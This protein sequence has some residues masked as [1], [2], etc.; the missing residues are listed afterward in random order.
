MLTITIEE[1]VLVVRPAGINRAW[2]A[3]RELRVKLA[4]VLSVYAHPT[5]RASDTIFASRVE[6]ISEPLDRN[7]VGNVVIEIGGDS[8]GELEIGVFD[9]P[10]A[11]RAIGDAVA[12][13]KSR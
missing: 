9:A 8:P 6:Y 13:V 7:H 5:L 4:D 3:K 2:A 11:A 10:A 12:Q 1:G